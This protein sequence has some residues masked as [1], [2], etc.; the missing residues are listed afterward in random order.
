MAYMWLPLCDNCLEKID[1]YLEKMFTKNIYIQYVHSLWVCCASSPQH[2]DPCPCT[3]CSVTPPPMVGF[4]APASRNW[5]HPLCLLPFLDQIPDRPP[6]LCV[7]CSRWCCNVVQE[8]K[9]R[10]SVHEHQLHVFLKN[11]SY[12]H[13]LQACLAQR[14]QKASVIAAVFVVSWGSV[15]C[16]ALGHRFFAIPW[17]QNPTLGPSS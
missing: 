7:A 11:F 13:I 4:R 16:Y 15:S 17:I 14:Q 9:T 3:R 2:C 5:L 10:V 6:H 12:L 8:P 1:R